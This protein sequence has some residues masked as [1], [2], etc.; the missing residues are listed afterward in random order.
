[1]NFRIKG[2][3]PTPF[4]PLFS[5]SDAQLAARNA[6]RRVADAHGGYPCR[7]S[8]SDAE[9]GDTVMLTHFEHHP[10]QSP[11]RASHAIYISASARESY[12]AEGEIPP[13][14]R[15]RL[16]SLRAYDARGFMLDFDVAQGASL[17][18]LICRFLARPNAAY[19]HAHY[20]RAGCYAA[21]VERAS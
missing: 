12:D 8:L 16:I 10:V 4:A 9:P 20:A 5:L 14:L 19:L 17:P 7:V 18:A 3:S 21:L 1:M 2:L 6:C 13:S 15:E 11:Y